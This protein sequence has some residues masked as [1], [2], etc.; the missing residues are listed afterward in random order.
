[1]KSVIVGQMVCDCF[2]RHQRVIEEDGV[3][4]TLE[5]GRKYEIEH[6][7]DSVDHEMKD[8]PEGYR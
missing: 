6:C 8:H 5:D 2:F 7:L 4:A 3:F 1:M